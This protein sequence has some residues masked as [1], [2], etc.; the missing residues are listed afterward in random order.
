[1]LALMN[2]HFEQG[3]C[4]SLDL[5][6]SHFALRLNTELEHSASRDSTRECDTCAK[7][8]Q[9]NHPSSKLIENT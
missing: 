1:M 3:Q 6:N 8:W 5:R 4:S 9:L 7:E 2:D